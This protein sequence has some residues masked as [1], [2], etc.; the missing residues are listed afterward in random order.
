MAL[1]LHRYRTRWLLA[2]GLRTRVDVQRD[3]AT[4]ALHG[5]WTLKESAS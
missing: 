4:T 5:C 2:C 3:N 1:Q